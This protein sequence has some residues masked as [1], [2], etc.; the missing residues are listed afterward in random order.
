MV[1]I[2]RNY[3]NVPF[4]SIFN[5]W[6]SVGSLTSNDVILNYVYIQYI[7]HIIYNIYIL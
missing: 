2:D 5:V 4:Y 3:A 6:I 1:F 7:L